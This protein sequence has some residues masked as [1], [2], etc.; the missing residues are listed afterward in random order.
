[1]AQKNGEG[2]GKGQ[3]H[4]CALILPNSQPRLK[5]NSAIRERQTP[6][7]TQPT[8]LWRTPSPG[9]HPPDPD[10][11]RD[12]SYVAAS[13]GRTERGKCP[14]AQAVPFLPQNAVRAPRPSWTGCC[15]ASPLCDASPWRRRSVL[16]AWPSEPV[17]GTGHLTRP[18]GAPT[19]CGKQDVLLVTWVPCFHVFMWFTRSFPGHCLV[20]LGRGRNG[21]LMEGFPLQIL[22]YW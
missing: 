12:Q 14:P 13:G 8:S 20:Y 4:E 3:G 11:G 16:E 21:E 22:I 5:P 6:L 10:G 15:G 7:K 2:G 19:R 18:A 1:M 9:K 17:G